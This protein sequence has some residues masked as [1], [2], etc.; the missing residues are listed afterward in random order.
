M[1]VFVFRRLYK[2][3]ASEMGFEEFHLYLRLVQFEFANRKEKVDQHPSLRASFIPDDISTDRLSIDSCLFWCRFCCF[4]SEFL[5][6]RLFSYSFVRISEVSFRK[7]C[8]TRYFSLLKTFSPIPGD[9]NID[10][11]V[12][13]I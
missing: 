8:K 13:Q 12:L 5:C 2:Q 4:I 6:N 10:D 1:N 9:V 7:T 11:F 3:A